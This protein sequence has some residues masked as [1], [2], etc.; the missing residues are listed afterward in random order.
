MHL[1]VPTH[2]CFFLV[3]CHPSGTFLPKNLSRNP[4]ID[5]S[6]SP[7]PDHTPS[8]LTHDPPL[9][10]WLG[11]GWWCLGLVRVLVLRTSKDCP[12][13][14]RLLWSRGSFMHSTAHPWPLMAWII[15]W[16]PI[17]YGLLALGVGLCLI[18]GFF[19][20]SLLFCSFYSLATIP[21]IPLYHSCCDVTWP[22]LAG[23]FSL[24]L[25]LCYFGFFWPITLLVGFFVPFLSSWA[26]L[27]HLLFLGIIGPFPNLHSYG[28]LLTLLSFTGPIALSFILGAHGFSINLLLSYFITLDLLW[29]ILTFLHR[30]MPMSLL[31]LSLSSFRPVC[32]PQGPFIYFMDLWSII[33]ATRI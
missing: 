4:K 18:V 28:L 22:V 29:P 17:L 9:L 23:L 30:I 15:F 19:S 12:L 10:Y 20:F 6:F 31:L 8:P 13:L 5:F 7:P 33:P 16:F 1:V 21:V 32:F 3:V 24:D 11:T 2:H 14:I 27:A 26:S 25:Y